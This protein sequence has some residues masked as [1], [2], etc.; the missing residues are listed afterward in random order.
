M[1]GLLWT[2]FFFFRYN[3]HYLRLTVS[4]PKEEKILR[5]K[6]ESIDFRLMNPEH[7]NCELIPSLI[8]T[9]ITISNGIT[10]SHHVGAII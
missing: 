6:S 2:M 4:C 3:Q 8:I 9:K 10:L 1:H 7:G 5:D